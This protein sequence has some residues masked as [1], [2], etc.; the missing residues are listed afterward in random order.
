MRRLR[1][2]EATG[3]LADAADER[4]DHEHVARFLRDLRVAGGLDRFEHL[5][6]FLHEVRRHRLDRLLAVPRTAVGRAQPV[7]DLEEARQREGATI[8]CVRST[9]GGTR[10]IQLF[11]AHSMRNACGIRKCARSAAVGCRAS[12]PWPRDSKPN[13]SPIKPELQ[14]TGR[15]TA[16]SYLGFAFA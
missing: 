13:L 10:G 3:F 4:D 9:L 8:G 11:H 2:V 1:E 14:R 12:G 16:G 5:V 7:D 15:G 6:R